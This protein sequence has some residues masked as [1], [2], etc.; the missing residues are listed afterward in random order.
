MM[1]RCVVLAAVLGLGLVGCDTE[2]DNARSVTGPPVSIHCGAQ[3]PVGDTTVSV[4]CPA[5]AP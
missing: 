4:K 3:T 1:I 5:S 2:S